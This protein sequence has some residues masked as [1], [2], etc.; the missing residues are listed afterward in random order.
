LRRI[1]PAWDDADRWDIDRAA[2]R[3]ATAVI[4]AV[5]LAGAAAWPTVTGTATTIVTPS[6]MALSSLGRP[7]A[8]LG[9]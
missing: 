2:P 4:D 9:A 8:A 7:L 1:D 6:S 5:T 3:A